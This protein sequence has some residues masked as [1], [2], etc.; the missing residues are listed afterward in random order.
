[1]RFIF[2]FK[3]VT[4]IM[5][6]IL[7]LLYPFNYLLFEIFLER[8]NLLSLWEDLLIGGL[9]LLIGYQQ[10]KKYSK[11]I[12]FN[13]TIFKEFYKNPGIIMIVFII[14]LGLSILIHFNGIKT[15]IYM[16]RIYILPFVIYFIA[17]YF[18]IDKKSYS[19][20]IKYLFYITVGIAAYGIIESVF[21]GEPYLKG[22][23]IPITDTGKLPMPYYLSGFPGFIRLTATFINPNTAS[24]F[25]NI[26]LI[27]SIFNGEVIKQIKYHNVGLI[28]ILVAT[29]LTV[30][31]SNL[32]PLA[33]VFLV[34][35]KYYQK[36]MNV[37]FKFDFRYIIYFLIVILSTLLLIYIVFG[38]NII[39]FVYE[40]V[41]NTITL[42]DT[43]AAGRL[44]IWKD[45]LDV[46]Y[47]NPLGIGMGY[48]GAKATVLGNPIIYA[49]SSYLTILIDFGIPTAIIYFFIYISI[50]WRSL[51]NKNKSSILKNN[52]FKANI[53]LTIY[54]FIAIFFSNYVHDL[55]ILIYY[56]LFVGFSFNENLNEY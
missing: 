3:K 31:R 41:L 20:I 49:E 34:L 7:V 8:Y 14:L 21:L 5:L 40:F 46:V 45:A 30:S 25:F 53:I 38:V 4:Y 16:A 11:D 24:F 39:A 1:M 23:G 32:L 42:K 26:I 2:D 6:F 55:E 9:F 22:I 52:L 19:S 10:F 13:K 51:S 44:Y 27:I 56:F 33:L 54:L 15:S 50:I 28:I 18:S 35:L 37:K 17:R 29:A 36:N 43:S 47:A 48:T 12:N